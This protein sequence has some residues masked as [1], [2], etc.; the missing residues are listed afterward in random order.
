[1]S[2]LTY[3][4]NSLNEELTEELRG[5]MEKAESDTMQVYELCKTFNT[6]S[7]RKGYYLY[8][9]VYGKE[10]QVEEIG[11]SLTNLC[12]MGLLIDT[13][14]T[15]MGDM[16]ARNKVYQYNPNPPAN[17]IKI[18]IKICVPLQ[19]KETET[20]IELDMESMSQVF[21]E[22]MGHYDNIILNKYKNK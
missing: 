19:F 4:H 10:L 16:G 20:G 3:F 14:T 13:G 9:E 18:P 7:R 15:E 5:R 8:K 22:K 12:L 1:M 6:L 17:P 11:R 2:N 21:I